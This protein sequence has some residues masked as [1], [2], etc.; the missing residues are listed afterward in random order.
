MRTPSPVETQLLALVDTE[1]SGREVAKLYQEETGKEMPYGTLYTT[2][3]RLKEAGWVTS[4][5]DEDEDGRVRYFR[6][7]GAGAGALSEARDYYR[8]LAGF[9]L[10][11]ATA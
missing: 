7:T 11:R 4:R 8:R 2:F 5:D 10:E 3:R 9:A 1:L 6:I